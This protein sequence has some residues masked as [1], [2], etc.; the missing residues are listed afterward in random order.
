METLEIREYLKEYGARLRDMR[1]KSKLTQLEVAQFIGVSQ[2][3]IS[4]IECGFFL[5]SDKLESALLDIYNT[6]NVRVY[7]HT[8]F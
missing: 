7:P 3:I 2:A 8:Y 4:H 6:E 5:S 1:I